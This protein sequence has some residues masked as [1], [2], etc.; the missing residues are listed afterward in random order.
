MLKL[1]LAYRGLLGLLPFSPCDVM[2][3]CDELIR[4]ANRSLRPANLRQRRR[5]W[6]L[7]RYGHLLED[8]QVARA[9]TSHTTVHHTANK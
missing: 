7:E 9:D 3:P 2:V 5:I 1:F 8:S 6:I 4:A